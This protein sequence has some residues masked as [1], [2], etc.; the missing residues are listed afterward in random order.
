MFGNLHIVH[1]YISPIPNDTN[2]SLAFVS[3]IDAISY[4]T[5]GKRMALE[6]FPLPIAY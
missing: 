1:I 4:P 3:L 2:L 5:S 6:S